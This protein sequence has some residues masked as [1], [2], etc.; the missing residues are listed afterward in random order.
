MNL[1]DYFAGHKD[2]SASI[3]Y[4]LQQFLI[5]SNDDRLDVSADAIQRA[6][7]SGVQNTDTIVDR[8]DAGDTSVYRVVGGAYPNLD[9]LSGDPDSGLP[10][11]M[12]LEYEAKR[13]RSYKM[14]Q[15]SS[16]TLPIEPTSTSTTM[17]NRSV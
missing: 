10:L 4:H 8:R 12:A 17:K 5:D 16:E 15:P 3:E 11:V 7:S 14:G 6:P 2:H 13:A 9:G 1:L